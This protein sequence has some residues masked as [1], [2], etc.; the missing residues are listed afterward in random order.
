MY[1]IIVIH[2]D[3]YMNITKKK[4][5][6]VNNFVIKVKIVIYGVYNYERKS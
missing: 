6:F 5:I 3:I 1:Q 2:P 4:Y